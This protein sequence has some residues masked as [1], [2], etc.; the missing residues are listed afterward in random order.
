MRL[1]RIAAK[2][3]FISFGLMG[4]IF[5]MHFTRMGCSKQLHEHTV[6]RSVR[7]SFGW[8]FRYI[9]L[10]FHLLLLP[11]QQIFLPAFI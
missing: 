9:M 3:Y 6:R 2:T 7:V 11:S 8:I 10:L 4:A 5:Q 1:Q